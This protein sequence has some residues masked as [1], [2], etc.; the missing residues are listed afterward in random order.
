MFELI[1]FGS[2]FVVLTAALGLG[3]PDSTYT[4]WNRR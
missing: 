3:Y 2:L 1:V 4:R